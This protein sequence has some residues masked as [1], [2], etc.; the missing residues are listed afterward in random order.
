MTVAGSYCKDLILKSC[1]TKFLKKFFRISLLLLS[2][3]TLAIIVI[4]FPDPS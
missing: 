3:C 2:L 1:S 4:A